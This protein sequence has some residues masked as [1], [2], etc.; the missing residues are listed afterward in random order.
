[1]V[2]GGLQNTV[3]DPGDT[4]IDLTAS[5]LNEAATEIGAGEVVTGPNTLVY[6]P[7][8]APLAGNGGPT[9]THGLQPDSPAIDTAQGTCPSTDQRGEARPS[10]FACDIGAFELIYFTPPKDVTS[11]V[12]SLPEDI[13]QEATSSDGA[14][15]NWSATATDDVDASVTVD[16]QSA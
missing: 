3:D 16:C 10:G 7:E 1:M 4:M 6:N 11:P 15:V 13:T 2:S 8:L 14:T 5:N 12:L 9:P